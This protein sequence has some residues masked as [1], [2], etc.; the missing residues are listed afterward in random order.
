MQ[1]KTILIT[2]GTTGIGLAT[3]QLLAA[4]GARVI[5]TGRNPETLAAARELLPANA[6][7]LKSAAADITAAQALGA[8][9]RQQGVARLDGAFFNAGIGRFGPIESVAPQHFDDMFNVNVRGLFFQLQS[10]LP[11]LANPSA[12]LL[13]ASVVAELGLHS[14]SVYS[15]TKAAVVSLGKSLA[16]EL[17][18]RG[19]R[20][21]TL[22][23]GPIKT[24]IYNKLGFPADAQKGFEDS[25]ASQSL[26]KRFGE[27][28]EVAK[29]ARFL[30]S[31]DSSYV[32]GENITID[33]G[34]R[35]T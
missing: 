9:L 26:F 14:T 12:V 20:V 24:P 30:L 17:S 22:S 6:L 2:G 32:I 28:D 15:A 10:V 35:L 4:D 8:E 19:I 23:P 5:V 31:T 27:A 29:L 34:V 18:S 25:M 3:A 11:L 33:G 16:V 7:V 1:N 13:N 21:N